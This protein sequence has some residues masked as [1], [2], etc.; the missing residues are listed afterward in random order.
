MH[1]RKSHVT[2]GRKGRSEAREGPIYFTRRLRQN[3]TD[4]EPTTTKD[5]ISFT[6]TMDQHVCVMKYTILFTFI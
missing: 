3:C 5:T 6:P 2:M 1:N 4:Q